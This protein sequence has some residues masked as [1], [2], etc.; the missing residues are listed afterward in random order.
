[1]A[2][3]QALNDSGIVA[4]AMYVFFRPSSSIST[5]KEE[6]LAG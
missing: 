3:N 5:K 1:V 6:D 4:K 2:G